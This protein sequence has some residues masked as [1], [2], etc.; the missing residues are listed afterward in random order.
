MPGGKQAGSLALQVSRNGRFGTDRAT[1]AWPSTK[2]S[3]SNGYTNKTIFVF[4]RGTPQELRPCDLIR[5][6]DTGTN[7]VRSAGFVSFI[8]CGGKGFTATFLIV[9]IVMLLYALSVGGTFTR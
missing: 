3:S 8:A 9:R 4:I 5:Q 2:G 6:R 1:A 7:C